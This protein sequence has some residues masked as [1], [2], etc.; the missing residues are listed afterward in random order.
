MASLPRYIHVDST[1]RNRYQFPEPHTFDV[2][3]NSNAT[4]C[5]EPSIPSKKYVSFGFDCS[6]SPPVPVSEPNPSQ[7]SVELKPIYNSENFVNPTSNSCSVYTI[8]IQSLADPNN[9]EQFAGGNAQIPQLNILST[10]GIKDYYVGYYIL[11]IGS[12]TEI[13]LITDYKETNRTIAMNQPFTS[14]LS[15]DQYV[16]LDPSWALS[17]ITDPSGVQPPYNLLGAVPATVIGLLPFGSNPVIHFQYQDVF[18]KQAPFYTNQYKTYYAIVTYSN[19]YRNLQSYNASLNIGFLNQQYPNDYGPYMS[20][21]QYNLVSISKSQPFFA[22]GNPAFIPSS[23]LEI[24]YGTNQ[25]VIDTYLDIDTKRPLYAFILPFF[26]ANNTST[27]PPNIP[28]PNTIDPILLTEQQNKINSYIY[29]VSSVASSKTCNKTYL[30]LTKEISTTDYVT[31]CGITST[32]HGI[33]LFYADY[34]SYHCINY[35]GNTFP[36][37]EGQCYELEIIKLVLPNVELAT[38]S[39]IAFYPYIMVE[40]TNCGSVI[41]H[42]K[43]IIESNNPHASK[44]TFVC[45]IDDTTNPVVSAFT[46]IDTNGAT[47]TIKFSPSQDVRF[48]VY[49]PDGTPFQPFLQD[50]LPPL[51]P[52]RELQISCSFSFRSL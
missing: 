52:T 29:P 5:C 20:Y 43:F 31:V 51:P 17:A 44:A 24:F 4:P 36:T 42:S 45:P 38:G 18:G 10:V 50:T 41:G 49:L 34:D 32:C 9:F 26:N 6:I 48:S 47:P 33:V 40:F 21:K 39:R 46:K 30:E 11:K 28:A 7:N 12:S 19:D 1:Y 2:S 16:L 22:R 27:Y 8:R 23:A 14:F 25:I 13:R 35:L 3:V 15:T 37:K